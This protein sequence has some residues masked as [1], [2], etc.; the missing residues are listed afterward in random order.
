[1]LVARPGGLVHATFR[2]LPDH[3]APGDL[4]VFNDSATIHAAADGVMVGRGPVVVHVA[5]T[6]D[7]GERVVELRTAPD[8]KRA[9]LDA[10]PG[11][12]VRLD[13]PG[14]GGYGDPVGAI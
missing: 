4:V 6:L 3:L 7:S 5:A 13:L 11:D 1:M 14:G 10:Q 8:A 2:D 12:M 9:V